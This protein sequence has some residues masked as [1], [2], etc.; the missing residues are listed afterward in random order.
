MPP[1]VQIE[2]HFPLPAAVPYFSVCHAVAPTNFSTTT[3][4]CPPGVP[5]VQCLVN[6]CAAT[7]CPVNTVC[8]TNY[9]GSCSAVCKPVV[10]ESS[11]L[12]A[13]RNLATAS[14]T[15]S[16]SAT[17]CAPGVPLVQCLADPCSTTKCQ[18]GETCIS[19]FCGGCNAV[20][21]PSVQERG[22][23]PNPTVN[24]A[25]VES[26]TCPPGVPVVNC[27]VDPCLNAKC[28]NE[29]TCISSYCGSC[30]AV[31]KPKRQQ[32][33]AASNATANDTARNTSGHCPPG[34]RQVQCLVNPC[35]FT[36][37][38]VNSSCTVDYCGGCHAVCKPISEY[39]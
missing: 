11:V 34:V 6:P 37:C 36:T 20:C 9:C 29:E 4:S 14:A 23:A 21:K 10:Q 5:A 24:V 38:P 22:Q 27:F 32:K 16:A 26:A 7:L 18:A 28:G 33:P 13:P 2:Q 15:P 31:C 1:C 17:S 35:A 8:E 39:A 19:N 12:A 3:G 30:S 25:S